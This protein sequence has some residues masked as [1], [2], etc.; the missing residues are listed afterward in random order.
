MRKLLYIT[1]VN[2]AD[3]SAQSLQI[4][5]MCSAFSKLNNNFKF[6]CFGASQL[7]HLAQYHTTS[8]D[9]GGSKLFRTI[10]ICFSVL[11]S[12]SKKYNVI[13]RDLVI[14]LVFSLLRKN[15]I[16]EAHQETSN[17]AKTILKFLSFFNN[18]KVL[19]IS[20]ALKQADEIPISKNRI[21]SY[22][23]GCDLES[24]A[25]AS[26]NIAF[27]NKT[28][29]YSG[30]LHKGNDIDS[31]SPLFECF[32]DWDFVF[33]GGKEAEIRAYSVRYSSFSNVKFLGRLPHADVINYQLSA[34]VLLFPLTKSNKL[35]KYTSPLKLFEYMK[36]GKPIVGSNIG[37]VC[38]ILD[39]SNSFVFNE[40]LDVVD[41]FNRYCLAQDEEVKGMIEKNKS[42]I[43]NRYNWSSRAKFILEKIF[44]EW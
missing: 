38:E 30:A 37:S 39:E 4:V 15:V 20:E 33:I 8:L 16:W 13:T 7:E 27:N 43:K 3:N 1:T 22:H 2:I 44:N 29:L 21:Y 34:D 14:A 18:F 5:S 26:H 23:D 17:S 31:L 25:E 28:A 11:K 40:K 12:N 9:T 36:A 24:K 42:L 32:P 41:A 6:Y 35:W 19:T 10:K